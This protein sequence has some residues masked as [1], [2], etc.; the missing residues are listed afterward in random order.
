MTTSNTIINE[1]RPARPT[2]T[3]SS[4]STRSTSP[5]ARLARRSRR[6]LRVPLGDRRPESESSHAARRGKRRASRRP[7]LFVREST[8]V[9]RGTG[10]NT[11]LAPRRLPRG[12]RTLLLEHISP[13]RARR[14]R[15]GGS[16]KHH[17]RRVHPTE[18]PGGRG[19]RSG[20]KSDSSINSGRRFTRGKNP[21]PSR[22]RR[23]A[24]GDCPS[25][26]A[27][28]RS[29][30]S[31]THAPLDEY[32]LGS[33]YDEARAKA[34]SCARATVASPRFQ[35]RSSAAWP[36]RE[37]RD[38][39]DA[40]KDPRGLR[41]FEVPQRPAGARREAAGARWT[42]LPSNSASRGRAGALLPGAR[43][44][45]AGCSS[46]WCDYPTQGLVSR[47]RRASTNCPNT[48]VDD[49]RPRAA[50]ARLQPFARPGAY[51]AERIGDERRGLAR[52]RCGLASRRLHLDPSARPRACT[53]PFSSPSSRPSPR[54]SRTCAAGLN[55][56]PVPSSSRQA[57]HAHRGSRT[58]GGQ[59]LAVGQVLRHPAH[60]LDDIETIARGGRR[61]PRRA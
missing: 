46:A 30:P 22:R 9:S 40:A 23:R 34:S 17:R 50:V 55:P 15:Q 38:E 1:P 36:R 35:P 54:A 25:T 53:T 41:S 45:H 18:S 31:R 58:R 24:L 60:R 4:I 5:S 2:R 12:G 19:N 59:L 7:A 21:T 16:A 49:P 39:L 20:R 42:T 10:R 47:R 44:R 57:R 27:T 61:C 13:P 52:E 11:S 32:G 51:L 43:Q 37:R 56:T 14:G 3:G 33:H 8:R 48:V 6:S 26:K 28:V 29:E